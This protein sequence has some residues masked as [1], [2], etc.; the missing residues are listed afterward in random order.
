MDKDEGKGTGKG[1]ADPRTGQEG[2]EG[3]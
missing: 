2:P 3:E 1:K